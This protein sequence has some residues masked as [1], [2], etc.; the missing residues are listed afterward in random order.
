[1]KSAMFLSA[2][3]LIMAPV[4]ETAAQGAPAQAPAPATA[5]G[6]TT[7]PAQTVQIAVLRVDR[8]GLPPI[9]RLE[10]PP[11][12]LGF[13]GARLGTGAITLAQNCADPAET[14]AVWQSAVEAGATALKRPEKVF[15]GGYSGYVADPDGHV[16]DIAHN[17]FWPLARDGSLKLP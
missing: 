11:P 8:A 15:W 14:D 6:Q 13:A 10:L 17:P 7:A 4:T 5:Q 12:D 9:S 16:R 2:L 1:M 3:A